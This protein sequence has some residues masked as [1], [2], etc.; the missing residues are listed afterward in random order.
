MTRRVRVQDLYGMR[1][2][3]SEG[4]VAGR[5]LSIHATWKGSE[6]VVTEYHLGAAALVERLGIS[7]GS[8]IGLSMHSPIRVSWDQMDFSDPEKPRLKCRV[9]ELKRT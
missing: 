4:K 8:L 1:V 7:A 2:H 5:I 6:C 3:D 9:D